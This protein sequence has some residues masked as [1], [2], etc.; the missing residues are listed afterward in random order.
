MFPLNHRLKAGCEALIHDLVQEAGDR[1][2]Y[3]PDD[4]SLHVLIGVLDLALVAAALSVIKAE[5]VLARNFLALT[6]DIMILIVV[7]EVI[8]FPAL[9]AEAVAFSVARFGNIIVIPREGSVDQE[10]LLIVSLPPCS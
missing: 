5:Q 3:L 10:L 8:A 6:A 7:P 9:L 2:F 4:A 1:L